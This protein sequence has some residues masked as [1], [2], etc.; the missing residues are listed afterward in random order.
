MLLFSFLAFAHTRGSK[1]CDVV[2]RAA[3]GIAQIALDAR[4]AVLGWVALQ[5]HHEAT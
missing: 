1:P 2:A 3:A 5:F 4:F